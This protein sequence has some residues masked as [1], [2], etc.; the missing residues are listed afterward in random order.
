MSTIREANDMAKKNAKRT[1]RRFTDEERRRYDALVQQAEGDQ[2]E[3]LGQARRLKGELTTIRA[4]VGMLRAEREA[5]GLSLADMQERTGIQRSVL[6]A[7][8]NQRYPNPTIKT[9]IRYADALN[10]DI[11]VQLIEKFPVG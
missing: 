6:S 4:V 7:L 9:L 10:C 11:A 3:I 5:Q 8:E 1:H 2:D